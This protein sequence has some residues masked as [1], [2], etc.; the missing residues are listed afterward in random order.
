MFAPPCSS[1]SVARDR[2]LV[3]RDRAYPWG[4]PN[5]PEHEQAKIEV[6]N[7][8]FRATLKIIRAPDFFG[9][10]WILEN[11]WSS[12]CWRLPPIVKLMSMS[13]VHLRVGDFCSWGTPWRKRTTFMCGNISNDDSMRLQR[14][15]T[16]ERGICGRTGSAHVH[17]TGS[18]NGTPLTQ[19]AQ[20]YPPKLCHDLAHVLVSHAKYN[21]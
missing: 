10:P 3:I 4:R 21:N 17:L 12:K 2:T 1:F 9:I 18:K 11:P 14:L 19:I 8:C 20:P 13:H 16:G 6:G 5:L 7:K 15:C